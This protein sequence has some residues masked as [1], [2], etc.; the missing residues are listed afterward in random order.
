MNAPSAYRIGVLSDTHGRLPAQVFKIFEG[1]QL[2]LHAG[3]VGRD[4]LLTELEALAPTLAVSGNMDGPPLDNLRPLVRQIETPAGRIA[5]THG[6]LA[7]APSYD[8][9]R[10][11]GRFAEFKPDIV[12]F[13]HSHI[14]HLSR[15]GGVWLFNPGSA[16]HPRMGRQ[17]SVGIITASADGPQFEHVAIE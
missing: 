1:V 10:L 6:H 3:D 5:M 9:G 15:V 12:I 14:P 8:H 4:D 16:G 7:T 17:P 2:I 13:G 11:A